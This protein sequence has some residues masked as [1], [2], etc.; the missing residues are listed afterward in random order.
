MT[1][2]NRRFT[3]ILWVTL[4]LLILI[5]WSL[6]ISGPNRVH[7]AQQE[8]SIARIESKVKGIKGITRH[9]FDYVTYQGYTE[10][11]LYWFDINGEEITSRDMS[12]LSYEKATKIAKNDYGIEPVSIFLGY[13]YNNPCYVIEGKYEMI[14]I[15]Y[16]TFERIYERELKS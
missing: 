11:K 4:I 5:F 12:T 3:A 1:H 14:L 10:K 13:G 8:Q 16:D 6:F 7:E 2:F 9:V 15:D